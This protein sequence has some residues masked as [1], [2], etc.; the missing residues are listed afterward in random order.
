MPWVGVLVPRNW[1]SNPREWK[2]N[3]SSPVKFSKFV[4]ARSNGRCQTEG[5]VATQYLLSFV[6]EKKARDFTVVAQSL[7]G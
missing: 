1:L 2:V 6:E 3:V 5:S 4:S 7:C